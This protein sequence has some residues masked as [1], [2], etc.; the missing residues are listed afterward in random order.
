MVWDVLECHHAVFALPY[1][2]HVTTGDLGGSEKH[3]ARRDEVEEKSL[4]K[5]E[6]DKVLTPHPYPLIISPNVFVSDNCA[7][8]VGRK[9]RPACLLF[10]FILCRP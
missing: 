10:S 9:V 5:I 2:P 8:K 7:V 4:L 6:Q 3:C 1:K